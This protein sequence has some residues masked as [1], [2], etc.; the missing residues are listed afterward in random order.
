MPK[1][2]IWPQA[3]Q[4]NIRPETP[5]DIAAIDDVTVAAFRNHPI[6]HQTEQFIIAALRAADVLT[7]SLVADDQG[8][9]VGH[10]AFSPV[11]I[12]DGTKGWYGMGP[13]SIVPERQRQGIGTALV[14]AGLAVLK[15]LRG[16]GCAL[17]G[18][19]SYYTR[20]GFRNIPTLVYEGIPQ[21]FFLCL[22][23]TDAVP[24][25]VVHFDPAFGAESPAGC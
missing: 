6:S 11:T 17:V 5:S 14:N 10:I 3:A 21:E 22:P 7:V 1:C 16:R 12:S 15:E 23:F 4:M 13:L 19:P 25:G 24:E 2:K 9:V 20:F 8:Q 18:Y